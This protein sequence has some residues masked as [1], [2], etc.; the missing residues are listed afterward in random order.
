MERD[1]LTV[2]QST[3]LNKIL[4]RFDN[5]DADIKTVKTTM[6]EVI[7]SQEFT[8]KQIE[9]KLQKHIE[10]CHETKLEVKAVGDVTDGLRARVTYQGLR[11]SDVEMKIEQLERE[12]RKNF[13]IIE[14]VVEEEGVSSPDI[15]DALFM[16]L[17]LDFD[18]HVCDRV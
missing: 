10:D 16:D 17:K 13:M 18:S 2:L 11:L 3:A 5:I 9:D 1:E 15:V 4:A 14:G 7:T 12:R 6:D 8:A